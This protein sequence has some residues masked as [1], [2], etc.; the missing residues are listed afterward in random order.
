MKKVL[1]TIVLPAEVTPFEER[2]LREK[3]RLALY[4]FAIH[5]PI[6]VAIAY[7]NDTGP[8]T[9]LVLTLATLVGPAIAV[10]S[11]KSQR[12]VSV[13]HGVTAML[14]GGLLVHFG[15]GPVQIEMH[16]YFFALLAMLAIFG[17]PMV[18]VAAAVT[19][20][21]H[22][23]ILWL[24]L[25]ESVFNYDAPVW[26]VAVHAAFVVLESAA[27][28]Y[29]A[30]SFFDNVI[31]LDKIVQ[32]R[33]AELDARNRDMHLV[34]DNVGEGFF[35]IDL[36]GRMSSERSAAVDRFFGPVPEEARYADYI[37]NVD[38]RYA[39]FFGISWDQIVLD[40]FPLE[41]AVDQ[42]PTKIEHKGQHFEAKYG[43]ICDGDGS[44][45]KMLVT[46]SNVTSEVEQARLES[47]QREVLKVFEAVMKDKR[48]FLEFL[49]EAD[50]QVAW[51]AKDEIRDMAVL[52]RV[53]HTL[54][55][56]SAIFGIQS[57]S[58]LCHE[59]ETA[60]DEEKARPSEEDR[61]RLAARWGELRSNLKNLI[62][63]QGAQMIEID[64][65]EYAKTLEAVLNKTP[66][67]EIAQR[68]AAW[69]L[70]PTARRLMRIGDQARGVARRLGKADPN[71]ELV[72]NDLR[73]DPDRWAPFF[74][75]FVHVVR[76]A[77]DH[78]IEAKTEREEQGKP[79]VATLTV[80]TQLEAEQFVIAIAD[81]GR[82]IDFEV[83][84]AKAQERGIPHGS[85]RDLVAAL[86]VDGFSTKT[87]VTEVSGRG[88]G[89]AAVRQQCQELGGEI[90]VHSE[91]GKGTRFEFRFPKS[92]LADDP[93][94]RLRAA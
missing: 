85:Q 36:E 88:V 59:M 94:A 56:N 41:V 4:F 45:E 27:S 42:L 66:R 77:V 51:I 33:T 70:E 1:S 86:F 50:E 80:S 44:L 71:V 48:G 12:L 43:P 25:P 72:H 67:A 92:A 37:R 24:W 61:T 64:D 90:Q 82:G 10:H 39:D 35:T 7:F 23:L 31:G 65:V 21:S 3:N 91:V 47:Q 78:G 18:V 2:Y 20:A 8:F 14:M 17:N 6:F 89:L 55:G 52:K 84:R 32:E 87:E 54:K 29:I 13:I 60:I 68:I 38:A 81:D 46:I 93:V 22:H 53:V 74:S 75:A 58:S 49:E 28:V 63:E 40:V 16:F 83:I 76:N 15:Q 11:L 30:R 62:G 73:M 26:V 69:A 19:A 5:L 57:I 9:A 34:L 79:E